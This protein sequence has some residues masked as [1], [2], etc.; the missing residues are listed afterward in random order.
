[1]EAGAAQWEPVPGP[2]LVLQRRLQAARRPQAARQ[3]LEAA[4]A[5]S[6]VQ[7]GSPERRG[8]QVRTRWVASAVKP[9]LRRVTRVRVTDPA[10]LAPLAVHDVSARR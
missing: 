2:A 1:M 8:H 3:L 4:R 10:A 5:A 7:V 9:E 6:V